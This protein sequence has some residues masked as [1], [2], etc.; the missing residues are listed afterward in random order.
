MADIPSD[1]H[2]H[3]ADRWVHCRC[4]ER[5]WGAAGAAG[6]LL[7]RPMVGSNDVEVL[8]QHRA[9]FSHHGGTW[10]LP[11]GALASTEAP[12]P[13]ALREAAEE[14]LI[15]PHGCRI[16]ATH[17]FAHPDWTYTTV[18]A[19]DIAGQSGGIGDGES[20][21]VRWVPAATLPHL[22][23]LP[24]FEAAWPSLRRYLRP[25]V[26]VLDIANILGSRPDGWWKDRVGATEK[27]LRAIGDLDGLPAEAFTPELARLYPRFIAILEGQAKAVADAAAPEHVH[28][29][30]SPGTGDDHIV[31]AAREQCE[32][33]NLVT[34][35][36]SDRELTDRL[37]PWVLTVAGSGT[38]TRL[39]D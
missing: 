12:I 5:H 30:R 2:S 24:A 11:G 1:T 37:I 29:T 10:G 34:A 20:L 32:A 7:W 22:A 39:L 15:S 35:I 36:T 14:A 33:G 18:I 9:A 31:A 28:L 23:L 27:L 19:E 3:D 4:G 26:T 6:L 13:G 21:D 25:I 38:I 8:V 16:W 17:E